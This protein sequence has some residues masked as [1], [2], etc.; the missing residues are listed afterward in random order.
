MKLQ[1]REGVFSRAPFVLPLLPL[2]LGP[3]ASAAY[4]DPG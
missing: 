2:D 4:C 3:A 1:E